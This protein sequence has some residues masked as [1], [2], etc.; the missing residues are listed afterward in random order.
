MKKSVRIVAIVLAGL[1]AFS[2]VYAIIAMI[3]GY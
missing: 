1:F 3:I 2:I